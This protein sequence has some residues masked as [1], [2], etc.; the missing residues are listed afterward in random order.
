MFDPRH[1]RAGL[2]HSVPAAL[3]NVSGYFRHRRAPFISLQAGPT[4]CHMSRSTASGFD[5]G[6]ENLLRSGITVEGTFGVPLHRKN[7]MIGVRAFD[8]FDDA[9]GRTA[10][11]DS[12]AVADFFGGLMVAGIDQ[13]F[14]PAHN[15]RQ[16]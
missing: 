11:N 2:S 3:G 9:V 4:R 6:C 10:S 7:E 8:G 16:F 14:F 12:Q 1:L 15:L 5:E 13:Q